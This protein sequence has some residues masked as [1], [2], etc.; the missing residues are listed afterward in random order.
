[1]IGAAMRNDQG[2]LT[3]L[4]LRSYRAL[5]AS[6]ACARLNRTM[7]RMSLSGLGLLNSETV[8]ASG[9]QYLI[10]DLLPA[11]V[12]RDRPVF[13]D[14]GANVGSYTRLLRARFPAA[15]I[16]AFE[17][18]PAS[19]QRLRDLHLPGVHCHN[20]ALG[21]RE[22]IVPLYD[23][24]DGDGS[25]HASLF[26]DV[27]SE[28]HHIEMT[29]VQV[30]VRPLDHVAGEAGIVFVDCLKIDTEGNEL[31]VLAGAASLIERKAIASIHFEFN[32]MNV[33]SRTFLR[34]FR[35]ILPAYVLY[36]LLPH[37]L[38]KLPDIAWLTELF[39]YQN[40]LAVPA[41]NTRLLKNVRELT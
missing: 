23:R 1:M 32:E 17:P 8:A 2:R 19:F 33:I 30:T 24:R 6:P 20:L 11:L 13:V 28:L 21:D 3:R 36:R 10:D 12:T 15:V 37:G 18:H 34:D 22:A 7:L 16:H 4:A 9:E 26:P 39:A 29:K 27:I 31:A 14:V 41:E 40:I 5:F 38:L 25:A 35:R